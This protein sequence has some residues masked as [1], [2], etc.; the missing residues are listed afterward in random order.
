MVGMKPRSWRDEFLDTGMVVVHDALASDFCE[1]VV[2]RHLAAIGVVEDDRATWP[3]GRLNRPATTTYSI[4]EAAPTAAEALYELVG[5]SD[6]IA[7]SDLPDNL[8]LNFPDP[9]VAWWAPDQYDV[10]Q[11]GF[12]KDGDWF[13]HFLDSPEQALLGIVF[14]RDVTADQGATYVVADSIAPV[15]RLLADHPEGIDPIVPVADILASCHDFRALTGRQ[16]TIVWAHPFL[17]HSASVNGT[18]RIRIISNTT[19][20]LRKPIALSGDGPKTPIAQSILGALG[21]DELVF[22][23]S[24]T[25]GKV[26]SER[27]RRWRKEQQNVPSTLCASSQDEGGE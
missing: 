4:G 15:A 25:R 18:D 16:G 19:V 14:W 7:F 17:V 3:T 5:G 11:A 27:E 21:V 2:V 10:P 22:Q 12:H 26:E 20:I 9:E 6:A 24:G 1:E 13:R 23:A 8:I